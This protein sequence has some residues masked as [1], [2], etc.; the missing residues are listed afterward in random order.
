MKSKEKFI[1]LFLVLLIVVPAI[2]FSILLFINKNNVGFS[3][4]FV[5]ESTYIVDG[6][7]C[8]S[9]IKSITDT[10]NDM[11]FVV[12]SKVNYQDKTLTVKYNSKKVG[13]PD[14]STALNDNGYTLKYKQKQQLKVLNAPNR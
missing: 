8:K 6:M 12:K 14:F 5:R 7:T 4:E 10:L 11:K 2:S 13:F 3:K 9:C 1:K